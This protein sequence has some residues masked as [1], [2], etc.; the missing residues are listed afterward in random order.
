MTD[1]ETLHRWTAHITYRRD[2]G[3]ETRQHSFEEIEQL[4]DIVE[5]GPNFY[6]IKSIVIVPNGR[7][8]PMTIEQAERA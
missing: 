6:A 4:H 2:A 8:E 1:I 3:D 5:R 7:C